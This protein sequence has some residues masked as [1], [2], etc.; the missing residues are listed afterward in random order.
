MASRQTR[1]AVKTPQRNI[2]YTLDTCNGNYVD[3]WKHVVS[4]ER[5]Q[6]GDNIPVRGH[7]FITIPTQ[8]HCGKSSLP[9]HIGWTSVS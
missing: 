3:P 6:G 7:P 5:T 1:C 4:L 9:A 8:V 2:L